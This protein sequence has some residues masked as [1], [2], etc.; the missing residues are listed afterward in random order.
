MDICFQM[1]FSFRTCYI[2]YRLAS[3]LFLSVQR[4]GRE[5]NPATEKDTL[6]DVLNLPVLRLDRFRSDVV[7]LIL[8]FWFPLFSYA[9][10][11]VQVL[12]PVLLLLLLFIH[13]ITSGIVCTGAKHIC[14][15]SFDI[16]DFLIVW[17]LCQYLFICQRCIL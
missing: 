15:N 6:S 3:L 13:A 10:E 9:I 14:K 7:S 17:L 4:A 1:V 5:S 2:F 12:L 16:G 8:I 11:F